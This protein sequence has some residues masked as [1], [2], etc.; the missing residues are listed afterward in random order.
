MTPKKESVKKAAIKKANI[1]K[2]RMD[3]SLP[4][5]FT[6]NNSSPG[7]SRIYGVGKDSMGNFN[8][9]SSSLDSGGS[10]SGPSAPTPPRLV[11]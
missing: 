3:R 6:K 1:K 8:A 9:Q 11:R 2:A 7:G 5:L 4:G 10:G